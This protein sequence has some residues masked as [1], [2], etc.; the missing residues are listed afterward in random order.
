MY[1]FTGS[2]VTLLCLDNS[3]VK[4]LCA[5]SNQSCWYFN[6][7]EEQM[8][9]YYIQYTGGLMSELQQRSQILLYCLKA[10]TQPSLIWVQISCVIWWPRR[11]KVKLWTLPQILELRSLFDLCAHIPAYVRHMRKS[12]ASQRSEEL[13]RSRF[14]V[15]EQSWRDLRF[16]V[17]EQR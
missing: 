13:E 6:L 2:H 8:D 14:P 16:P 9:R 3:V 10:Y 17:E 15:E 4:G 1:L 5:W 12:E 7:L 11:V